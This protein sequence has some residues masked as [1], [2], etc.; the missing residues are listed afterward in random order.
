MQSIRLPTF[1]KE[2]QLNPAY[3]FYHYNQFYHRVRMKTFNHQKSPACQHQL[4][5]WDRFWN[6]L[7]CT[8][9]SSPTPPPRDHPFTSPRLDPTPLIKPLQHIRRY[10]RFSKLRKCKQYPGKFNTKYAFP[11]TTLGQMSAPKKYSTFLPTIYSNYRIISRSTIIR[12]KG[13]L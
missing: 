8:Q 2:A 6:L 7:G 9:Y 13:K 4:W 1:C 5:G 3:K 10:P 12:V 11:N